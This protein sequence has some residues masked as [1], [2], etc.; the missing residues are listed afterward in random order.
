MKMNLAR[1]SIGQLRGENAGFR[2]G[3][4]GFASKPSRDRLEAD[5]SLA[6]LD[7]APIEARQAH[8]GESAACAAVF[9]PKQP[10]S[11]ISKETKAYE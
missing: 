8:S 4:G 9:G 1:R 7:S 3:G 5:R 11:K 10:I 2:P 6:S